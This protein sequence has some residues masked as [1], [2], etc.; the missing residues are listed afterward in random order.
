MG[1]LICE[2][3][4]YFSE[5]ECRESGEVTE[6]LRLQKLSQIGLVGGKA[7]QAALNCR[8]QSL[9]SLPSPCV[10]RTHIRWRVPIA[11]CTRRP[12]LRSSCSQRSL[13][14]RT[15]SLPV[16]NLRPYRGQVFL[17]TLTKNSSK[18]QNRAL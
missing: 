1:D 16:R 4:H 3:D 8:M 2:L 15:W 11:R 18:R 10:S 12:S 14:R 17:R 7:F 9:R 5:I 13:Q 6:P